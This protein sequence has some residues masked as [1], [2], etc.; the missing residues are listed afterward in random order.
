MEDIVVTL[1]KRLGVGMS[2]VVYDCGKSLMIKVFS[3]SKRYSESSNRDRFETCKSEAKSLRAIEPWFR[4]LSGVQRL[5]S[6]VTF[7]DGCS[8]EEGSPL[9]LQPINDDE[10]WKLR[11]YALLLKSAKGRH[12]C[13]K[14]L[15]EKTTTEERKQ[16]ADFV[17]EGVRQI[18]V[19]AHRAGVVHSDLSLNNILIVENEEHRYRQVMLIDWG[20]SKRI[21]ESEEAKFE[22][23]Y[24]ACERVWRFLMS[25]SSLSFFT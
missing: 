7:A 4:D 10:D 5:V 22:E 6:M 13:R 24:L 25:P 8:M 21:G 15:S 23:D 1:G 16:F 14:D 2:G 17:A 20:F 19:Q 12:I 3:F 18:V 9:R 11:P